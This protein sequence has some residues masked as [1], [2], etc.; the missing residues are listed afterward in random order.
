MLSYTNGSIRVVFVVVI[1]R[2][3]VLEFKQR[4]RAR[5]ISSKLQS[6][7]KC[8]AESDELG[9]VLQQIVALPANR[10][11]LIGGRKNTGHQ[12]DP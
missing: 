4:I 7:S 11:E 6:N 3:H 8:Q 2:K 1:I 12:P 9:T 10:T 5:I